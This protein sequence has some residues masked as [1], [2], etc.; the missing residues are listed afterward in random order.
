MLINKT[1]NITQ[2]N[3]KNDNPFNHM[4]IPRLFEKKSHNNISV[5][6][7]KRIYTNDSESKN[8]F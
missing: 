8:Y 1:T 6:G 7:K 4:L 2:E 3:Y 5:L